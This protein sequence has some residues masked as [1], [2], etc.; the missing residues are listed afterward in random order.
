MSREQ[1]EARA[2][3]LG[4]F[5]NPED[6][7]DTQLADAIAAE[8]AATVWMQRWEA[9]P[10]ERSQRDAIHRLSQALWPKGDASD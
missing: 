5:P 9:L 8:E 4:C 2:R 3:E 6:C 7:T 10:N 1:L